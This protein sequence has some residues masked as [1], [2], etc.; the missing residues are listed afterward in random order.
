[1]VLLMMLPQ[2]RIV[3]QFMIT[4]P[5]HWDYS[6]GG[7]SCISPPRHIQHRSAYSMLFHGADPYLVPDI[8]FFDRCLFVF[9]SVCLYAEI[10]HYKSPIRLDYILIVLYYHNTWTLLEVICLIFP[11]TT[12]GHTGTSQQLRQMT[13]CYDLCL[14]VTYFQFMVP[15]HLRKQNSLCVPCDFPV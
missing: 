7:W 14:Q 5:P 15:T 10:G 13:N 9:E 3:Y 4:H 12:Q 2:L 11:P 1:M 6:E 8:S